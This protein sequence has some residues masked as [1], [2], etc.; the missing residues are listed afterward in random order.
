MFTFCEN[1]NVIINVGPY[2]GSK[3]IL[4]D[5]NQY[6]II[7]N[8]NHNPLPSYLEWQLIAEGRSWRV[9]IVMNTMNKGTYK[10]LHFFYH[11]NILEMQMNTYINNHII[12]RDIVSI[13]C[14]K[15]KVKFD[16]WDNQSIMIPSN[17]KFG[18]FDYHKY[19]QYCSHRREFK[20]DYVPCEK[21][22]K[23]EL[24]L[25]GYNLGNSK[26]TIS[27]LIKNCLNEEWQALI[28]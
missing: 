23:S 14:L 2:Q 21:N 16:H 27:L 26:F 9:N 1:S 7:Y 10:I 4:N 19:Q 17:Y 18:I 22:Y 15:I 11:N 5:K 28:Y 12:V 24:L 25:L 6:E 8:Y 3:F 20:V 13:D